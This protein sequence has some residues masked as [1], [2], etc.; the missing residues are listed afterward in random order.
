MPGTF[1]KTKKRGR[2]SFRM[3]IARL[4][5]PFRRS[6][7]KAPLRNARESSLPLPTLEKPWHGGLATSRS[8]ET[9]PPTEGASAHAGRTDLTNIPAPGT[10][11]RGGQ[12]SEVRQV[13][14]RRDVIYLDSADRSE[15]RRFETE[16]KATCPSEEVKASKPFTAHLL[17][18]NPSSH[19]QE[20]QPGIQHRKI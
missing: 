6:R 1:S 11:E 19:I 15:P 4:Y 7:A 3:S 12:P 16:S 18:R 13:A 8:G 9:S 17:H 5:R 2:S 10:E 14:P 20:Q